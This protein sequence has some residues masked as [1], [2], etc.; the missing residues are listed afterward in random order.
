M[1]KIIRVAASPFSLDIL[2]RG[3][4]K[5]LSNYYE[6]VGVASPDE[7][8][9][10]A[11]RER[12]GIRTIELPIERG[13]SPFQDLRSLLKLYMLFHKEHPDIVHSLT[14][15]AG[16]LTMLASWA[17]RVPARVHTFTGL[18]FPWRKGLA[19]KLL[20]TIDSITCR[21]ATHI[22]PEGNGVKEDLIKYRV[23]NKTLKILANGNINGVDT[24][25][26]KPYPKENRNTPIR[27]IFVGRIVKDKGI[28]EL[29]EAF[30][31]LP[32]AELLFVGKFEQELNPLGEECYQ[33][34]KSGK[35]VTN[36]GFQEDI[37]P[38]LGSA[39]VLVLPSHRE[40]F[41]NS[42]LQAGA[43]GLPSIVTNIC[44]CNEI[45]VDEVTGLLVEPRNAGH[46]YEAMKRLADDPALRKTLGVN[47]RKRVVE[48]F[49][50]QM[51]WNSLIDFY[52]PLVTEYKHART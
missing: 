17:V 46:L 34:A 36:V 33:W 47:A 51:V 3:Q 7:K 39:D 24:V 44:G 10:R 29:K 35:R 1:K 15:K 25:Y 30:E 48:Q 49:S 40:G 6:V 9:H 12:E 23:T 20:K 13:I 5:F 50:Q 16:F 11:I 27:F 14:P 28:E 31:R 52:E 8:I 42:P 4:L 22:I 38:F 26:F 21:L 32:E 41:P 19:G 45:V 43:M 37:R 2:L 18:I